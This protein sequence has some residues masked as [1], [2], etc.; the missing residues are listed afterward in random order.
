MKMIQMTLVVDSK[1]WRMVETSFGTDKENS[2]KALGQDAMRDQTW[3]S[4]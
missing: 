3:K 2:V 1:V 4:T